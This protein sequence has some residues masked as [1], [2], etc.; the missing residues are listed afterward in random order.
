MGAGE[1][2]SSIRFARRFSF[3]AKRRP[4]HPRWQKFESVVEVKI[5]PHV[6]T[7][8]NRALT[9]SKRVLAHSPEL[10]ELKVGTLQLQGATLWGHS[11]PYVREFQNIP[12]MVLVT[13]EAGLHMDPEH[14]AQGPTSDVR[15]HA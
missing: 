13:V 9:S 6:E 4:G 2:R 1:L 12:E 7:G 3:S 11:R 15:R 5:E 10:K 8:Q 14:E